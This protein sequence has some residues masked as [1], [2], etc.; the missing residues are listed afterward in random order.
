M[1]RYKVLISL[2]FILISLFIGN[3]VYAN[4]EKEGQKLLYQDV[5]INEDGSMKV[6]EALW[7][8]GDYNGTNRDI[9]F[10][11]YWA[12]PFTGIYSN[13]SG[14]SDIYDA[15]DITDLKVFDISQSNFN[16][17]ESMYN[18]EVLCQVS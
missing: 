4:N 7:L 17:F 14:E 3:N 13:F 6:R 12:Y 11:N 5:T 8:N 18:L 16:S 15:T 10:K 2:F 9:K 1:K